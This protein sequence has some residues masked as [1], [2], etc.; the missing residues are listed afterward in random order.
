MELNCAVKPALRGNLAGQCLEDRANLIEADDSHGHR[1]G[2]RSVVVVNASL[3]V[4]A[5]GAGDREM[6]ITAKVAREPQER[7]AD[8]F[9]AA[10][11]RP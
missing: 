9:L 4:W 1:G 6:D 2:G 7:E 8:D 11:E 10:N 5:D 3:R